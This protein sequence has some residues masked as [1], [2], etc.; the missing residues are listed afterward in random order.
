MDRRYILKIVLISQLQALVATVVYVWCVLVLPSGTGRWWGWWRAGTTLHVAPQVTSNWRPSWST[1]RRLSWCPT[2]CPSTG[3]R[4]WESVLKA[5]KIIVFMGACMQ[6]IWSL[7]AIKA[8]SVKRNQQGI[9][10]YF[11]CPFLK[12]V[13]GWAIQQFYATITQANLHN[14]TP[15]P[16]TFF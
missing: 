11:I 6:I 7:P 1:R 13:W 14:I 2:G 4:T 12:I 16:P 3:R 5:G 8:P 10:K 9:Y 15:L